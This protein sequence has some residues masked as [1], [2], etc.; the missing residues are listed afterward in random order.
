MS[1]KLPLQ[2]LDLSFCTSSFDFVTSKIIPIANDLVSNPNSNSVLIKAA[3]KVQI[4]DY[5]ILVKNKYQDIES[6]NKIDKIIDY[7]ILFE[8]KSNYFITNYLSN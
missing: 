8:D 7:V 1:K 5:L 2:E 6:K 4:V 3:D